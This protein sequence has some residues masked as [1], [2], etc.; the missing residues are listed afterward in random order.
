MLDC[1]RS[2][3]FYNFLPPPK[4]TTSQTINPEVETVVFT[5]LSNVILQD[6]SHI[7]KLN[8]VINQNLG[9][10]LSII[11]LTAPWEPS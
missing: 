11:N 7:L 5:V 4:K 10:S 9:L 1:C 6:F 3:N 2:K 8:D